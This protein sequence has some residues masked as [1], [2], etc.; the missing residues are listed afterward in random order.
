MPSKDGTPG[1][2]SPQ[3]PQV[4]PKPK[5]KRKPLSG[6]APDEAEAARVKRDA[7]GLTKVPKKLSALS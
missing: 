7:K 4:A 1:R 2:R 5:P 6:T 3:E